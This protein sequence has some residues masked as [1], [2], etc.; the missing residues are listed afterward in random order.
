V[1]A[2]PFWG[3]FNVTI[4]TGVANGDPAGWWE[5]LMVDVGIVSYEEGMEI[6]LGTGIIL[7]GGSD[8]ASEAFLSIL[9]QICFRKYFRLDDN[10]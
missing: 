4:T 5:S 9:T 3:L 1:K 7:A 8:V 10:V 6:G 2:F